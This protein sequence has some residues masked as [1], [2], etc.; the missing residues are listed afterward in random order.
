MGRVVVAELIRQEWIFVL[1]VGEGLRVITHQTNWDQQY[2]LLDR[3]SVSDITGIWEPV[4]FVG[5]LSQ[6][7][8]LTRAQTVKLIGQDPTRWLEKG[9]DE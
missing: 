3:R 1:R 9:K 5:N 4:E 6:V 7:L 2:Q 8:I